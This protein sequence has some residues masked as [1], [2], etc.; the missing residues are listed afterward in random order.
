MKSLR[1]RW[2]RLIEAAAGITDKR[3]GAL[4]ASS[5]LATALIVAAA[6]TNT[7]GANPLAALLG[8]SLA[9]DSGPAAS[10]EP[11]V[12][13]SAEPSSSSPSRSSSSSAPASSSVGPAPAS[14]PAAEP[15]P[16]PEPQPEPQEEESPPPEEPAPE[17]GPVKHVF[18]ISL[19]S[20]GYD[21]AFG[22][23][24]QA[25]MPY[26]AATLRPQGLLLTNFKLLG[27]AAPANGI[28]AIA[29][30]PP[31]ASTAAGCPTYD[32]MSA[33]A[34]ANKRGVLSGA[35]CI[36]PVTALT[37][38]D[39]LGSSRLS[40]K[41]YMQDMVDEA[42]KPANCVHPEPGAAEAPAPG[43]YSSKLNP[44]AYFHSLLDLGDCATNDVPLTEL[45]KDLRKVETTPSFSYVSPTP[46]NAGFAGTCAEGAPSG[47]AAADA[48]LAE[49]APKILASPAY[50]RDGL[51]IVTFAGLAGTVATEAGAE[52]AATP[53][54][55]TGTL[56]V[57]NFLSPGATDAVAYNP[58]SLLRS[59]E[60][61]FGLS[62]L[63][64]AA[65]PKVKSFAPALSGSNGGD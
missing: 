14:E 7:G 40:W 62:L 51:L 58:Y 13:E 11:A 33:T 15:E 3:L 47:A 46:C 57:S 9:A 34:T 22:E 54:L 17:L 60:E 36:Y 30:Q 43:A 12:T 35:G 53:S 10:P 4:I 65:G 19:A 39:Q 45:E 31:N 29:G 16:L 18:V 26:L 24:E 52:A 50:K 32:E 28:A 37:L 48:F 63:G 5:V 44:F 21:A 59:S 20:P 64:E 23:A 6:M 55:K 49:W 8:R 56:L 42:G 61:N 2:A 27:E 41:G 25:Q 38:A 1:A